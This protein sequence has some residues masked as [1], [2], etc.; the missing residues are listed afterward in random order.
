MDTAN[1]VVKDDHDI[2]HLISLH[3]RDVGDQVNTVYLLVQR[4]MQ[5]LAKGIPRVSGEKFTASG[6]TQERPMKSSLLLPLASLALPGVQA[7]DLS[8]S[9]PF[10]L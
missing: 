1:L 6:C 10:Y 8:R 7:Q 4:P 3:L 5:R 9:S 2:A